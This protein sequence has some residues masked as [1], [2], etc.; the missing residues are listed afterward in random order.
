MAMSG[1]SV[2]IYFSPEN[3]QWLDDEAK[4]RKRSRS[5]LVNIIVENLKTGKLVE[6]TEEEPKTPSPVLRRAF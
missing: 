2:S 5:E 3:L 6:K 1:S 4:K